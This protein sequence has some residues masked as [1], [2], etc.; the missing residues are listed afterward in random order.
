ME[1]QIEA[2]HSGSFVQLP[3]QLILQPFES[4]LTR[5]AD[6]ERETAADTR[7]VFTVTKQHRQSHISGDNPSE[8]FSGEA[9]MKKLL[10]SGV[11]SALIAQSAMAA[12][13]AVYRAKVAVAA[14]INWTG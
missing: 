2:A 10:L 4:R 14:P 6:D 7:F 11:A 13:L 12:D 9:A 3:E 8:L 5:S 1:G